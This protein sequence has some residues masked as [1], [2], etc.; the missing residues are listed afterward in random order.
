[1]YVLEV[2]LEL[3]SLDRIEGDD[4]LQRALSDRVGDA[5]AETVFSD[6]QGRNQMHPLRVM[7]RAV[8]GGRH[9]HGA[10][11]YHQLLDIE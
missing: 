8:S 4:S 5:A 7:R 11:A 10:R 3:V 6:Y 9:H 2:C 1:M